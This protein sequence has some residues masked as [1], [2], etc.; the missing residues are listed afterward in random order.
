M[1]WRY[2]RLLSGQRKSRELSTS[3]LPLEFPSWPEKHFVVLNSQLQKICCSPL[4]GCCDI[5]SILLDIHIF[6]LPE[7]LHRFLRFLM[8]F[9]SFS[10]NFLTSRFPSICAPG[11]SSALERSCFP[12]QERNERFNPIS[13]FLSVASACTR[14]GAFAYSSFRRPLHAPL[15]IS[16]DPPRSQGS[17]HVQLQTGQ[18]SWTVLLCRGVGSLPERELPVLPSTQQHDGILHCSLCSY[19]FFSISTSADTICFSSSILMSRLFSNLVSK[20]CWAS[21]NSSSMCTLFTLTMIASILTYY[22]SAISSLR[23]TTL[24]FQRSCFFG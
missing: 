15:T 18:S 8:E 13:L 12:L 23:R 3:Q 22:L 19:H 1:P 10:L 17:L 16:P 20:R 14:S 5:L 4:E 24:S 21:D 2:S 9:C 7:F 6:A 11:S